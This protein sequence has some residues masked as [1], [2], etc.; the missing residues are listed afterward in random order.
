ML[1]D[2]FVAS[3]TYLVQRATT[4]IFQPSRLANET[5]IGLDNIKL[6]FYAVKATLTTC[7]QL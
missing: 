5:E 7:L 2:I 3:F 1:T 6:S 4:Q